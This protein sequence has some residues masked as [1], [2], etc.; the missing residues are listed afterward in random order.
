MYIKTVSD[1]RD[2]EIDWERQDPGP[3][4]DILG[5]LSDL[6]QDV[7]SETPQKSPNELL[8][9]TEQ[10]S[11][12]DPAVIFAKLLCLIT[13]DPEEMQKSPNI[14]EKCTLCG[15]K[16]ALSASEEPNASQEHTKKEK[17]TL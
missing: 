13:T 11:Q 16:R 1:R 17:R 5:P 6:E 2:S 10:I 14:G 8:Q 9:S 7:M 15:R 3:V 12:K 4:I